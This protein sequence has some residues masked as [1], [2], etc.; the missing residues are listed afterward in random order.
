MLTCSSR[1][2]DIGIGIVA[3][4]T[5]V[6]NMFVCNFLHML[7]TFAAND[8]LSHQLMCISK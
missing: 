4:M 5:V 7:N 1:F 3:L 6:L 8:E 2:T